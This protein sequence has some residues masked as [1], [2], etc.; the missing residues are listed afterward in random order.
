MKATWPLRAHEAKEK[1]GVVTEIVGQMVPT[2]ISRYLL[3]EM[4]SAAR[5]FKRQ[6][7]QLVQELYEKP[8][9]ELKEQNKKHQNRRCRC[10][11]KGQVVQ[12]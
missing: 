5:I 11:W 8:T 10:I 9:E 3:M 6:L 4:V 12:S 2:Q 1:R 7:E